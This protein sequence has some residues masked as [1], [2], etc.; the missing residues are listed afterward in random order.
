[1]KAFAS[2]AQ[3]L[4]LNIQYT[5][6]VFHASARTVLKPH[7]IT[8]EQF[9]IL[10]ILRGQHGKSLALCDI[11]SR[12]IDANSNASRLLDKLV[13]KGLAARVSCPE[14]RRR[15]DITLTPEGLAV[16]HDVSQR[17]DALVERLVANLS[18]DDMHAINERLDRLNTPENP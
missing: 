17:M 11:S 2:E 13:L 18:D 3:K 9:N 16:T 14:D 15:V 4:V 10:R 7:D 6:S 12:M 8:P 5:A 1:M